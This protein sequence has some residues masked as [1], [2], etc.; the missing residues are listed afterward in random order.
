MMKGSTHLGEIMKW[1]NVG[2]DDKI[3]LPRRSNE[4][5]YA[6]EEGEK[7]INSPGEVMKDFTHPQ[8]MKG[9]THL[10]K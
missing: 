8:A 6:P 9:S 5:I 4:M 7:K 3:K 1:G 2:G 10:E